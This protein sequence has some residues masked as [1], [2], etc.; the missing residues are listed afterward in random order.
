MTHA[1]ARRELVEI[2]RQLN[3]G[4]LG[5]IGSR[6]GNLSVRLKG[7][8]LIT[9]TGVSYQAMRSR[10]LVEL[11]AE[12]APKAG[13]LL[14]SSEW[15][16]HRDVYRSRPEAQAIVHAHPRF[17]TALACLRRSIPAF[18]YM[19]AAAGGAD[20]RCAEYATFGTAELSRHALAALEDRRACLLANHGLIAFG[21]T[22]AQALALASEVEHLAAQ[23]CQALQI[24]EPAILDA[25]EMDRVLEKFRSYGQQKSSAGVATTPAPPAGPE[26]RPAGT[27][28]RRPRR[29]DPG[30]ARRS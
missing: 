18:H 23:Y 19:V 15:R 27:R 1:S 5:T 14:P 11:D 10:D 7:G 8:L 12:G 28:P 25:A 13:Q 20:I 17:A 3:A 22:L 30:S 24:G 2:A 6:S 4:G 16:F 26:P 21:E 29:P 9:P